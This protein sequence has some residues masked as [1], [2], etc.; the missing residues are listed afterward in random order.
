MF[1]VLAGP[2]T[3]VEHCMRGVNK[4]LLDLKQDSF[5][6]QSAYQESEQM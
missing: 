4:L 5:S 1:P 2:R 6:P 3:P